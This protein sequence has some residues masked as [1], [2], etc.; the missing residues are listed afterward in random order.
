MANR[1][2]RITWAP[3]AQ[4]A[5]DAALDYIAQ[6]SLGGAQKILHAALDL[7]DSL[8]TLGERG[9]FLHELQNPAI[10]EVFLHSYRLIKEVRESEI[11]VVEGDCIGR[12]DLRASS[13]QLD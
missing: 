5:L 9:R 12:R 1:R 6:D 13:C 8:E 10:R 3:S 4:A 2:R 11:E 7:A